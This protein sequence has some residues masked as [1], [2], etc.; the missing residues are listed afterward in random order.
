MFILF[1]SESCGSTRLKSEESICA[2][3]AVNA[4]VKAIDI[5]N[6]FK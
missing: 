6:V 3:T 1:L 5:N 4:Q 2:F